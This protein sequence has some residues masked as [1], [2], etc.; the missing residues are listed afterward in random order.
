MRTSAPQL[1]TR[2]SRPTT[3]P[4]RSER[5]K[6]GS[7]ND[8]SP[9]LGFAGTVE[10]AG[11]EPANDSDR[12]LPKALGRHPPGRLQA[13]SGPAFGQGQRQGR[14]PA[15]GRPSESIG[16]PKEPAPRQSSAPVGLPSD[17]GKP[18]GKGGE[19][20]PRSAVRRSRKERCWVGAM[21]AYSS[22]ASSTTWPVI[23]L[24]AVYRSIAALPFLPVGSRRSLNKASA[25]TEC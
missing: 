9:T 13:A 11:I 8:S 22:S 2:S 10:A 21:T 25:A 5:C 24:V 3:S 12:P 15:K 4:M 7:G 14:R 16:T 17:G 23:A 6:K 1:G 18:L 19:V 20:R